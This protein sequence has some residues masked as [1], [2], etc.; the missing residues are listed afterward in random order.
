MVRRIIVLI[1]LFANVTPTL[2]WDQPPTMDDP[3]ARR[4]ACTAKHESA[5]LGPIDVQVSIFSVPE[6]DGSGSRLYVG[7]VE[8]L[9]DRGSPVHLLRGPVAAGWGKLGPVPEYA[10]R[11]S[12]LN[13]ARYRIE[14]EGTGK[15][16]NGGNALMEIDLS[17][18]Q[19]QLR[20]VAAAG[21]PNPPASIPLEAIA[22]LDASLRMLARLYN[23][24]R[25]ERGGQSLSSWAIKQGYQNPPKER[26]H[27]V[28]DWQA[29]MD[30]HLLLICPQDASGKAVAHFLPMRPFGWQLNRVL[31]TSGYGK[32]APRFELEMFAD[33]LT[34]D[35]DG[36]L[37]LRAA[38]HV[39]TVGMDGM[40]VTT[41]ET[42]Y[43][44]DVGSETWLK[45]GNSEPQKSQ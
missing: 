21:E 15:G 36:R 4:I 20:F 2:A 45:E 9:F 18:T 16:E 7:L 5:M 43:L 25:W 3:L 11:R 19:A 34:P 8:D 39:V 24:K 13:P 32:G 40:T 35:K 23:L 26:P 28:E 44:Y 17:A 1:L 29:P 12:A 37:M 6:P 10:P 27:G 42:G 22:P 33:Y 41:L 31:S 14:R 30:S 38:R